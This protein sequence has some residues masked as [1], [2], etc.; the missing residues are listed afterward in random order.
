MMA[1]DPDIDLFLRQTLVAV[2]GTRNG[3]QSPHLA[4]VWFTWENGSAYMVTGRKS[5]KWRNLLA[6]P[7]ASLCVDD[8]YPPY[9]GVVLSGPVAEV[10]RPVYEIIQSMALRYLGNKEGQEF[11]DL[12]NDNP[13]SGV[14][15]RLTPD[16]VV[17]IKNLKT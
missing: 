6:Q 3:S 15:F 13:P 17:R 16:R 7:Y 2:L 11:A 1:I 4:P 5:T 10:D 9:A 14:V 12:N 8:R